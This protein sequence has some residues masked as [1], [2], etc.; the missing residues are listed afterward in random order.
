MAAMQAIHVIAATSKL[1][2]RHHGL[3]SCAVVGSG[4]A[5]PCG[6]VST[7]A[8]QFYRKL[9]GFDVLFQD[10]RLCSL[11][12]RPAQVLLLFRRRGSLNDV[13]VPGGV[14]PG[15][16]DAQGRSHMAF[17]IE[18]AWLEDWRNWLEQNEIV[19]ESTVRWERGCTS[20]Y[21]RDPDGNLLELA[22]PGIWANY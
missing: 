3:G 16:M 6:L 4:P 18:C 15:G 9:F 12:V 1:R 20:L 10:D 22:T 11:N 17:A 13:H 8:S 2:C 7:G 5:F 19:I 21:F 14:L